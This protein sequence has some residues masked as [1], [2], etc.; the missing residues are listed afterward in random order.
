MPTPLRWISVWG[1]LLAV[2][3]T[4]VF[5]AA[6][7]SPSVLAQNAET[8]EKAKVD[9]KEWE[10]AAKVVEAELGNRETSD[11]R[12]DELRAE[13]VSWRAA[14]LTE[15]TANSARIATVKEQIGVLGEAPPDGTAEAPEIAKKRQELSDQLAQLQ[16]PG[17]AA[18][19]AYRR[20]DGLIREIDWEARD[21]HADRLLQL[22][23]SP[24]NPTNW[25]EGLVGLGDTFIQLWN[26]PLT[27]WEDSQTRDNLVN[28]L[29][30]VVLLFLLFVA[31]SVFARR[32]VGALSDHLQR[33]GK[34]SAGHRLL[35][36]IAS[37]GE[38]AVPVIGLTAL[39]WALLS[40]GLTGD[41]TGMIA[42]E[43]PFLGLTLFLAIWLGKQV[44]PPRQSE[45]A[46]FSLPPER[47]A[48]GRHLSMMM[49]GVLVIDALRIQAMDSQRYSDA[50]TSITSF[51]I[52]LA[53][54]LLLWRMGRVLRSTSPAEGDQARYL[55][56]ILS[57]VAWLCQII[58]ILGPV[59]AAFGY[60]PAAN[61]LVFPAIASLG[62]IVVL[63]VLHNTLSNLWA[64]VTRSGEVK[65]GEGLAPVIF[66]FFLT[67]ASIPTFALIWGARFSD[68]TETWTRFQ[69]G[70]HW[71]GTQISPGDFLVF[72]A[73]FAGGFLITRLLQGALRNTILP[74]TRIEQGGRNALVSISGYAGIIIASVLAINATGIDLT[75]L[76]IVASA[77]SVGIGFGLQTVVQNFVSGL[78]LMIERPISEGDWILVNGTHGV[79]K[80]ISVRSTRIQ[81]F[82]RCVVIV[83]NADLVSQQVTNYT[84]FGLAGRKIIK[85]PVALGADTNKVETILREIVEAQ[86]LVILNP[87]PAILLQSITKDSLNFEI[88]MILRN[89]NFGDGVVSD[90]NHQ[91]AQRFFEEDIEIAVNISKMQVSPIAA[92]ELPP[93]VLP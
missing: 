3:L 27:A 4:L 26:E 89:I 8:T 16:A 47:R 83:P 86:P 57:F 84:R 15:Q 10:K 93:D 79:V 82:D 75:G 9:Y 55:L 25:T 11:E 17:I 40:S 43:L 85:I 1:R 87:P 65:K 77:L 6:P 53:A 78:I 23:P 33:Q 44:F 48:A 91:I 64:L 32:W 68:L 74:R 60:V 50:V 35:V 71:G 67:L 36:L 13:L 69:E 39:S 37:L 34:S 5:L 72:V 45:D 2:I 49:G 61:A 58:G 28:N 7:F 62:L 20:A 59:L 41:L 29:P 80:A 52:I 81:T 19:E 88:R 46:V 31:T 14:F 12:L 76:A 90:V 73:I 30:L 54:G 66:G 42:Q 22:W 92:Q 18:E 70:F 56:T 38:V 63:I 51:P 21:R 24:L